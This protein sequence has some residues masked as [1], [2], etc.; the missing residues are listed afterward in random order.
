MPPKLSIKKP[1]EPKSPSSAASNNYETDDVDAR[2]QRQVQTIHSTELQ[3]LNAFF[4][5]D[6]INAKGDPTTNIIDRCTGKCYNVPPE[7]IPKMFRLIEECRKNNIDMMLTEKQNDPSGLMFDFDIQQ[8]KNKTQITTDM[9]EE[10]CQKLIT[11]LIDVLDFKDRQKEV[12]YIGITRRPVINMPT[13]KKFYKDGFHVLIP[14][15]KVSRAI[16]IFIINKILALDIITRVFNDVKPA[17]MKL[18]TGESYQ[19]KHFLDVNSAHVPV[20]FI[21]SHTKTNNKPYQLRHIFSATVKFSENFIRVKEENCIIS[22]INVCYEFSMNYEQADGLIKKS[23]YTPTE[24]YLPAIAELTNKHKRVEEE[25]ANNFGSLSTNAVHD[26]RQTEVKNL[27]DLL[28]PKRYEEYNLWRDVI[29]ALAGT[30]TSYK[31]LAEYFS[32][33]WNKFN[34][35]DFEK[36]WQQSISSSKNKKV[37]SIGSIHYW[38]RIDNP[39]R[40]EQMRKES[41]DAVLMTMVYEQHKEGI[42]SHADVADIIYRLLQYKYITD[43][44][45]GGKKRVWYE[46]ILDDDDH[47]DGELYKWKL[48][49]EDPPVSIANYIS[50]RLPV[51]FDLALKRVKRHYD[52]SDADKS[53]WYKKV[54]DNF[55]ATMRKLGDLPTINNCTKMAAKRFAK[56]GFAKLLDKDP[57]VRGVQNGILKLGWGINNPPKLIQG[58][59]SYKISKFTEVPYIAFDPYDPI[60]KKIL[61]TLRGM[62]PDNESDSFDFTMYFLSS[63]LDGNPKESMIMLMVGGGSNG[64]SFLVELHKSAIGDT[65]GVKMQTSFLTSQAS[66]ADAATPAI[67]QLK[68]ATFAYYSETNKCE[69]LNEAR[70]KEITGQETLSGRRLNENIINFKPKCHHLV[71]SNNNFVIQSGDHGTWRRIIYNPLKIRFV[72][73]AND[74]LDPDDPFQREADVTITDEWT[75]NPEI[76]GRYLGFMVWMHY[77]LYIK[78]RGKVMKVPHP[79]IHFE[80]EKYRHSQDT[81]MKFLSTCLVKR[82][83]ESAEEPIEPELEKYRLWYQKTTN[84]PI[85]IQGLVDTFK[86]NKIVSKFIKSTRRGHVLVGHRFLDYGQKLDPST[87]ETYAIQDVYELEM[88]EGNAGVPIE[89]PEQ[90]YQKILVEYNKYK[91]SFSN[92][93]TYDV[94]LTYQHMMN[95]DAIEEVDEAGPS[96]PH[97]NAHLNGRILPAGVNL[98]NLPEPTMNYLT[99]EYQ[100][101]NMAGYFSDVET[102]DETIDLNA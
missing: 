92:T 101:G 5:S 19:Q 98:R 6:M 93:A 63:T 81:V 45:E 69:V 60:T 23:E 97:S 14:G 42:L 49:E 1:V 10:F 46:F 83:D 79:H 18:A 12:Y 99:D 22:D 24:K 26:A 90:Y 71:V 88:S 8:E 36:L 64:K 28:H 91:T 33:K 100:F 29:F 25:I 27:L 72:D 77:W 75:A 3:Q 32:R 87:G 40:Y 37:L 58:Y 43:I 41:A 85:A 57:I 78:Y 59:H 86:N 54:Y 2:V 62:F 4:V 11:L 34:I 44:P 48:C 96:E 66:S 76:R 61:I 102:D 9:L 17:P 13:G 16:K 74:V 52:E 35:I 21:G 70:M 65:Y 73:T 67:M 80:T 82:A 55:K 51:L 39:E 89:T 95:R 20:H 53:K 56:C 15:I 94:D 31:D 38:A 47:I 84:K 50:R 68:D 7:K 30:S